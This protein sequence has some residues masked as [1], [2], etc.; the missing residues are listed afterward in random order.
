MDYRS[1]IMGIAPK[2]AGGGGSFWKPAGSGK[3]IVRPYRFMQDGDKMLFAPRVVHFVA[4]KAPPVECKGTPDCPQCV[5]SARLMAL[6]TKDDMEKGRR[7]RQT[8]NF[9]FVFFLLND[10]TE[11]MI[12]ETSEANARKFFLAM[13]KTKGWA[14][15][16]P[17]AKPGPDGKIQP[18]DLAKLEEFNAYFARAVDTVCGP[19]GWDFC[20]TYNKE[21]KDK[22]N[23]W[24]I[25]FVMRDEQ[26]T[27]ILPHEEDEKIPNP[28]EVRNRVAAARASKQ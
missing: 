2:G 22:K 3:Y 14:G 1:Y 11:A 21:T 12:W 6:R 4:E 5:E 17:E 8:T 26:M 13:A 16:Y 23:T 24:A 15:P 20:I 9:T 25:D 27:K 19:K 28:F 10:P 7:L 18:D